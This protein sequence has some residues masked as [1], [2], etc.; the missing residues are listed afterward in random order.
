MRAL[1]A[2]EL[3]GAWER[4][5]PERPAQRAITLLAAFEGADTDVLGL[6][7]GERDARLLTLREATFGAALETVAACSACGEKIELRFTTSDVRTPER[8]GPGEL[9]LALD[10]YSLVYRLP[11]SADV[12]SLVPAEGLA[13]A[14]TRLRERCLVRASFEGS[15]IAARDLPEAIDAAL[16]RA[17]GEADPQADIALRTQ[18]PA[19][20][21]PNE[22]VFDVLTYFWDELNAWAQRT[23]RDVHMLAW[24][25]GWS[26]RE[27]L[28]LSPL[29]RQ[30]YLEMVN[31]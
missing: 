31:G 12:A 23:L 29:R 27:I 20:D 8:G 10:G 17:I 9:E 26:E 11:T 3:L 13:R 25:Y 30:A 14:R 22:V 18:C 7:L 19:C 6:P 4:A 5:Y 1:T 2:A 28:A 21:R 24:A 16:A 15:A